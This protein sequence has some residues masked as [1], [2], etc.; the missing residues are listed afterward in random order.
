MAAWS[1]RS[2][3]LRRSI[4]A[5]KLF[6]GLILVEQVGEVLLFHVSL[7]EH[8]LLVI[9]ALGALGFPVPSKESP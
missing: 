9:A 3:T 8:P 5:A 1:P 4:T 6:A 2:P 7:A